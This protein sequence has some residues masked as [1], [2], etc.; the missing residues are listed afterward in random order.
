MDEPDDSEAA[1]PKLRSALAG[2]DEALSRAGCARPSSATMREHLNALSALEGLAHTDLGSA[3]AGYELLYSPNAAAAE[4]RAAALEVEGL[5]DSI[6]DLHERMGPLRPEPNAPQASDAAEVVAPASGGQAWPAGLEEFLGRAEGPNPQLAS[7][8]IANSSTALR[9][10]AAL[11]MGAALVGTTAGIA[12]WG[13]RG[14][15]IEPH[16][17]DLP[18]DDL[19][20]RFRDLLHKQPKHLEAHRWLA[21]Y[22]H[23]RRRYGSAIYHYEWT[24]KL[25]PRDAAA[26]NNLAWLLL[27]AAK[28]KFRDP[29]RALELAQRAAAA[30]KRQQAHI[31]DTLAVA[32][33]QLGQKGK[34]IE[35]VREALALKL[36][37][38]QTQYYKRR[39]QKLMSET[40]PGVWRDRDG[41]APR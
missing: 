12:L 18:P 6:S 30:S 14:K 5:R 13:R 4:L 1:R 20:E 8:A 31:L 40:P 34:A 36:T 15:A 9:W 37:H 17:M 16:Q 3:A 2:L 10:L 23:R 7:R 25:K 41:R 22:A 29:N 32:L 27:T 39:E 19:T 33:F 26:L 21:D 38:S 35:T 11:L 28:T 24:I